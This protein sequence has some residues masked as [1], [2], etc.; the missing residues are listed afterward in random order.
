MD[1]LH[2][3][4]EALLTITNLMICMGFRMTRP[5]PQGTDE[6]TNSSPDNSF[7]LLDVSLPLLAMPL[8]LSS[9]I[10]SG[11][12][13]HSEPANALSIPTWMVH[14]SSILEWLTAMKLVWDHAIT[15][16]NPRWRGMALGMIPSHSSGLCACTYH[17]FYNSPLL[18][19]IVSLQALLTVIGNTTMALAAY[20]VY[21]YEVDRRTTRMTSASALA[22]KSALTST[23]ASASATFDVAPTST[24]ASTSTQ[25]PTTSEL[26]PTT[27]TW[28]KFK[29]LGA[30]GVYA[31]ILS[32][33]VF[34]I[35]AL[36]V[37]LVASHAETGEWLSVASAED[38]LKLL[39]V[40]VTL[41]TGAR[42]AVPLRAAAALALVP[43][44]ERLRMGT[45]G[46]EGG[47]SI[48]GEQEQSGNSVIRTESTQRVKEAAENFSIQSTD[49]DNNIPFS[50]SSP[51]PL[52]K[53]NKDFAVDLLIKSIALALAVKYGS[54]LIDLPFEP[55]IL[56]AISLIALGS[57]RN[58]LI[59]VKKIIEVQ[60]TGKKE[61]Y[62]LLI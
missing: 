10:L 20:R 58:V 9:G 44:V 25:A 24:S 35:L 3:G 15:S 55:T 28:A 21:K 34:W 12:L 18:S 26:T 53:A 23:S 19:G 11:D 47:N 33:L 29:S 6:E 36:P 5:Q 40:A 1:F 59:Y 49:T 14:S 37:A 16:G 56:S 48:V 50:T 31:Y 2:G 7:T 62:K 39:A 32:E 22:S 60:M 57:T 17:F 8:I 4:A 13:L 42:L 52:E 51:I 45:N 61:D 43:V 54:L 27:A 30:S 38:R 41:V 46:Q